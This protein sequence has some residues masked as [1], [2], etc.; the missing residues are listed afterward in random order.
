M[1]SRSKAQARFMAAAAHNPDFAKKAGISTSAAKEWNQADK[2][3]GTLKKGSDKP[4]KVKEEVLDEEILDEASGV[5]QFPVPPS[6]LTLMQKYA[7]SIVLTLAYKSFQ[8]MQQNTDDS[9]DQMVASK[10]LPFLKRF[11][12][13]YG[14]QVL[15]D[16]SMK[17]YVN[18]SIKMPIDHAAI[19][20]E[21]PKSL[22]TEKVQSII[23]KMVVFVTFDAKYSNSN[24]GGH[25]QQINDRTSEIVLSLNPE[26]Y[27]FSTVDGTDGIKNTMNSMDYFMNSLE[28]EMQHAFQRIVTSQVSS[29][30]DKNVEQKPG[31]GKM[32]DS[33]HASGVEFGPQTKDMINAGILWLDNQKDDGELSGV[34]NRDIQ[35]A[36]RHAFKRLSHGQ[37]KVYQALKNY[38][39]DANAK[40]HMALIYKGLA[41]HYQ[42]M[43]NEVDS[44]LDLEPTDVDGGED[45]MYHSTTLGPDADADQ[46]DPMV[47]IYKSMLKNDVK[48]YHTEEDRSGG[49]VPDG[50][51][52]YNRLATMTYQL[53]DG[54]SLRFV[55]MRDI[56]RMYAFKD[57]KN[58]NHKDPDG[59]LEH[60]LD[61][62]AINA[63]SEEPTLLSSFNSVKYFIERIKHQAEKIDL[64]E[65]ASLFPKWFE[66]AKEFSGVDD[67]NKKL[68]WEFDEGTLFFSLAGARGS[69]YIQD[70]QDG[71]CVLE[72]NETN[73]RKGYIKYTV[74]EDVMTLL[75][76]IYQMATE[77]QFNRVMKNINSLNI[78]VESLE[79]TWEYVQESS[80][81]PVEES[82]MRGFMDL[83]QD[84]EIADD[85]DQADKSSEISRA[86]QNK[87]LGNNTN[88]LNQLGEDDEQYDL[89]GKPVGP[90]EK[91][92]K[93][94]AGTSTERDVQLQEMP[95]RFDAFANQDRDEFVDKSAAMSGKTVPFT[96]HDSFD[97]MK[98]KN[99]SGFIAYDK[100]G[101]QLALLSGHVSNNAVNGVK[102]VFVE[103]AVAAKSNVKGVVYQMYM[104]IIN[105]GYSILSDGLHSDD[106]IKFW[107]RLLTSH[108]VYVVGDG[109]VI[110]RATPEKVHKYWSDDEDSPSSELRLLLVK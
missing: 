71:K 78:T 29:A 13:K 26:R 18:Q 27:K 86:S 14:A 94:N 85:I 35:D 12:Q 110:T 92:A 8:Q 62:T 9:L 81:K 67:P 98:I 108:T 49:R 99:G 51:N 44:E 19:F 5:G 28:H 47:R 21:L 106:A 32:D 107:T 87:K 89:Q 97:V 1:P 79:Q 54:S 109:E 72:D 100:Q 103:S 20:R 36:I 61:E 43:E 64:D 17:R 58:P 70:T 39:E 6:S 80:K 31:Y 56:I 77:R 63:I 42:E 55:K 88:S 37:G 40:K 104:D 52:P 50:E 105:A 41:K 7:S 48:P 93:V 24:A 83:V 3:Q 30:K 34:M 102:N 75:F 68:S 84:A 23:Q 90:N 53:R 25:A 65:M 74:V 82:S 101:K 91:S 11:Q 59:Y 57:G 60:D 38:K 2:K 76:S 73:E 95:Q 33:Y 22:Q 69:W 16:A 4:E 10:I 45:R 66:A 96:Q 15:N 46:N